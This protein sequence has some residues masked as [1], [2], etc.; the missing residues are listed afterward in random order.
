MPTLSKKCG[1][2]RSRE[3]TCTFSEGN[4]K[5][6]ECTN[7]DISCRYRQGLP[8][9]LR[10]LASSKPIRFSATASPSTKQ[11]ATYPVQQTADP[12][13][14]QSQTSYE[15]LQLLH[16]DYKVV[17][18]V[19]IGTRNS[20]ACWRRIHKNTRITPQNVIDALEVQVAGEWRIPT[21][22]AP[23]RDGNGY[24]LIFGPEVETYL[25]DAEVLNDEAVFRLL[26]LSLIPGN[27]SRF[28]EDGPLLKEVLYSHNKAMAR[29]PKEARVF[30]DFE[31]RET[32]CAIESV[33]D[34]F[35]AYLSWFWDQIKASIAAE[36]RLDSADM[37]TILSKKTEIAVAVP[38]I[39]TDN[40]INDFRKLLLE[41]GFPN[42][43]IK[44]EP[45]CA[46]AVIAYKE[47]RR[48][49]ETHAP[50]DRA[51]AMGRLKKTT[52]IILDL[53]HGTAD[54]TTCSIKEIEPLKVATPF[55]GTGS[56]WGAQRLNELLKELVTEELLHVHMDNILSSIAPDAT[57]PSD[58][59]L[60]A[61]L[62]RGFEVAKRRFEAHRPGDIKVFPLPRLT[63]P[64]IAGAPLGRNHIILNVGQMRSIF[65]TYLTHIRCLVD[66]QLEQVGKSLKTDEDVEVIA[67]GGG[68]LSPYILTSLQ[69]MYPDVK[70]TRQE[71]T[72][73]PMVA[74]GA[75]LAGVDPSLGRR[76]FAR[77]SFGIELTM[78]F[79]P[80]VHDRKDRVKAPYYAA[81]EWE[82][83]D[84]ACWGI[85]VGQ[86]TDDRP[87][88]L[89]VKGCIYKEE[90]D[91]EWP[92]PLESDI[93]RTDDPSLGARD[94][95]LVAREPGIQS[96]GYLKI[97]V[98]KHEQSFR[99]RGKKGARY[100]EI[101]FR[102]LPFWSGVA[103]MWNFIVHRTGT[104][105]E[106]QAIT[107]FENCLVCEQ[108]LEGGIKFDDMEVEG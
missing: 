71:D 2:C 47:L 9:Q 35:R 53:G 38:A 77:S 83:A 40:M 5:C 79:D 11:V 49:V 54:L 30:L 26:K 3:R 39:W 34:I 84:C 78:A 92:M 107:D 60:L 20:S 41:A 57:E 15:W 93:I 6:D 101:E 48:I 25:A 103:L 50:D 18:G 88:N 105:P 24:K 23:V 22:V 16:D 4:V 62:A 86:S 104:F 65:N 28:S 12:P 33:R 81:S 75:F 106:A 64:S 73:M 46:A 31:G 59:M 43:H 10:S 42:A 51:E 108:E 27:E 58:D 1:N 74:K 100:L 70:V 52:K 72:K 45:K 36:S 67:V 29:A 14:S 66:N 89:V 99:M 102:A 87:E 56:L 21:E 8:A 95:A 82:V 32:V 68:S 94:G 63:F 91:F 98:D 37:N 80:R 19:D 44:S 85:T 13:A 76:E 97:M 55:M 69:E 90:Q 61:P 7:R 17:V 96:A